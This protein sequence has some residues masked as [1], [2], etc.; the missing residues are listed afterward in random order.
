[1]KPQKII[2]LFVYAVSAVGLASCA[3]TGSHQAVDPVTEKIA[4]FD[5]VDV[6]VTTQVTDADSAV[7]EVKDA[8]VK[9]LQPRFTPTASQDVGKKWPGTLGLKLE[10]TEFNRVS[11]GARFILGPLAGKDRVAVKGTL[12]D[13]ATNKTIGTFTGLGENSGGGGIQ[14][15][16]AGVIRASTALGDEISTYLTKENM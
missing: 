16:D 6:N 15:G 3:T 2:P 8:V 13:L 9:A 7:S 14:I 4:L 12:I 11:G 1:M 5:K 10:I